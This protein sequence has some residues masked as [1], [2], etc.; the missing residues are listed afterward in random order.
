MDKFAWEL[1]LIAVIGAFG[2]GINTF[3]MIKAY[4]IMGGLLYCT[5]GWISG[6]CTLIL[7][8]DAIIIVWQEVL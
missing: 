6:I 4:S 1:L 7:I 3:A 8:I 2:L 5:M